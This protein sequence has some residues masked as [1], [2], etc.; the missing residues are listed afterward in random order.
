MATIVD[1]LIHSV[2]DQMNKNEQGWS[3]LDH[4]ADVMIEVWGASFEQFCQSAATALNHFLGVVVSEDPTERIVMDI[5]GGCPD[6]LI[7]NLLREL[8]FY[9]VTRSLLVTKLGVSGLSGEGMRVKAL[10]GSAISG[11][12]SV[13]IKGITY[14]GLIVHESDGGYSARLL[15]DV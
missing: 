1:D 3:I 12:E 15:F 11:P 2:S 13:E 7:V 10:F 5:E 9:F 6:E 14:H 8:L 4:P